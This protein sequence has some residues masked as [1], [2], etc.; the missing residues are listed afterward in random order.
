MMPRLRLGLAC[1]VPKTWAIS[2][3]RVVPGRSSADPAS[4]RES[5]GYNGRRSA[6]SSSPSAC[7]ILRAVVGVGRAGRARSDEGP[8]GGPKLSESP[9]LE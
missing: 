6:M 7:V 9:A 4:P 8:A 5:A 1:M 2:V 3:G